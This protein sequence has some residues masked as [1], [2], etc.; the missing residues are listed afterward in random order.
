MFKFN[1][2]IFAGTGNVNS[3]NLYL[4]MFLHIN[5]PKNEKSHRL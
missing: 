5:L 1:D 4:F 3:L 2:I